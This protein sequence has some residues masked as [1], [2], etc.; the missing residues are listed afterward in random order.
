M[1]FTKR[2]MLVLG[3]L[4][5]VLVLLFR[6]ASAPK[7]NTPPAHIVWPAI[8][9]NV[10]KDG[11]VQRM[12][13][14]HYITGV[15]LAEMAADFEEEALKAQAIVARTF[16]CKAMQVGKHSGYAV[17]TDPTCCQ[18]YRAEEEYLRR[19]QNPA[20]L[21]KIREAVAQTTGLVVTYEGELI[22]ATYFSCSGGRTEDAQAVWGSYYP[23]LTAKE[24]P[25]EEN[26][27]CFTDSKTFTPDELMEA[28]NLSLPAD[29]SDWFQ[30]WVYTDG[31]GVASVTIGG[32]QFT[33]LALRKKLG[34]RSTAFS[35][36]LEGDTVIFHTKGFGH[37]VGMSQY[38]ADAMA[39][40][41][42]TCAQIL[43][44]YYEG[45]EITAIR[46]KNN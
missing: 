40:Q 15:V 11:K 41:G 8:Y 38:G 35:V 18:G 37:R 5:I 42:K 26:A 14:E 6:P 2:E 9:L 23:Y 25:G 44:Y 16:A 17:C 39:V 24:S 13:L 29:P 31:E 32:R 45:T 27:F 12:E 10:C 46:E 3:G 33:G 36:E 4:M 22:E 21:L 28:L 43:S 19:T 30:D 1:G 7:E 34:L 20:A